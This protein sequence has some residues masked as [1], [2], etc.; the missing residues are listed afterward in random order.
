M[1]WNTKGV[2]LQQFAAKIQELNNLLPKFPGSDESRNIPQEELNKILLHDVPHG[3]SNQ[4][5]YAL[6][7]SSYDWVDNITSSYYIFLGIK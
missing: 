2:K 7:F 4:V 3:W 6:C 1:I 5:A